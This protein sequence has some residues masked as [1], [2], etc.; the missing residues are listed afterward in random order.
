[1]KMDYDAYE[2]SVIKKIYDMFKIKNIEFNKEKEDVLC[3]GKKI[4]SILHK[5]EIIFNFDNGFKFVVEKDDMKEMFECDYEI[6]TAVNE[7]KE[8]IE[9]TW[10]KEVKK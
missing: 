2:Y 10:V 9:D 3:Y 5:E 4:D 1:M 8:Q 6:E 7:I